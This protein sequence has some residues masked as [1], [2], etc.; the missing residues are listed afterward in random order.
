MIN[1]VSYWGNNQVG[2]LTAFVGAARTDPQSMF[3]KGATSGTN[4]YEMPVV[5]AYHYVDQGYFALVG[6]GTAVVGSGNI[7]VGDL[8]ISVTSIRYGTGPQGAD[9]AQGHQGVQ[10]ATGVQGPADGAQGH[11][12]VQGATGVQGVQ[13]TAGAQGNQGVQGASGTGGV[14][15]SFWWDSNWNWCYYTKLYWYWNYRC[16]FWDNSIY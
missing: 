4:F 3:Y 12:G 7:G 5:N 11:Q 2:F 13:G 8:E 14:G 15:I 16:G 10:G 6:V 9:G 1:D